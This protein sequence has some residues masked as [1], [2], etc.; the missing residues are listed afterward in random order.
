MVDVEI[1]RGFRI[2]LDEH[3]GEYYCGASGKFTSFKKLS[4]LKRAIDIRIRNENKALT[5]STR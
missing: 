4:T 5:S 2:Q 1:Y 3:S